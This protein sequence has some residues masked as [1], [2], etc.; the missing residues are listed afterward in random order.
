MTD[1]E[2]LEAAAR[3]ADLS[4]GDK[5]SPTGAIDLYMPFSSPRGWWNPITD[6]GDRYRL[7]R[8]LKLTVSFETQ[9]VLTPDGQSFVWEDAESEPYAFVRAAAAMAG[10]N[11]RQS[12]PPR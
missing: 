12:K 6:D 1:R 5:R 11:S 3:A 7:A 4:F 9:C 10:A 2:L 8:T